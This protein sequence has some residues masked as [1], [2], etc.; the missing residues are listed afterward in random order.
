MSDSGKAHTSSPAVLGALLFIT[1]RSLVSADVPGTPASADPAQLSPADRDIL[2]EVELAL[3]AQSDGSDRADEPA[4]SASTV[5][6]TLAEVAAAI[7]YVRGRAEA[8][9][10]TASR[11]DVLRKAALGGLGAASVKGATVWPPT[12]QTAVQRFGSWNDALKAA[13]LATNKIGRAKG[14]LRF[15]S[16]AYDKSI[17]EF[18]ADCEARGLAATYKSYTEY[19]AE[20]KGEVP[21]AAAVRKFYGS[22]NAAVA[23]V[24]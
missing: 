21:S 6:S 7:A 10:L 9:S 24:G 4:G 19:A 2:A 11:Y 18:L 5:T 12:S 17:G 13:G 15:D 14:Q 23:A 1:A 16:A 3:T 8:P 22:W 20:H